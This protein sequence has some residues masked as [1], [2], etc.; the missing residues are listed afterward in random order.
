[1]SLP[2]VPIGLLPTR[3]AL[4]RVAEH[5]LAPVRV[6]E[7]GHEIALE[8]RGAGVATPDL[9]HGGWVGFSGTDLVVVDRGGGETRTPLSTLREAATVAG[10]RGADG[11][12]E[13]PLDVDRTASL[14]LG[15][16]YEIGTRALTAL[17]GLHDPDAPV[18]LWPEHF[19]VAVELGDEAAGA[20]AAYGISP[21]DEQHDE[22]YAYV[23]PWA[24]P[25]GDAALWNATGFAGAEVRW[26]SLRGEEDPV[27]ALVAFWT[28][29]F[30][31][32]RDG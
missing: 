27:S 32:L 8:A 14:F 21:G 31:A 24:G 10:L 13:T 2:T 3:E 22:P 26:T 6:Q 25:R 11:L 29:R 28:A 17:A 19:D 7:T 16:V 18:R 12:D 30:I 5:V 4:H 15:T 20:R 23:A 1:M 9:P